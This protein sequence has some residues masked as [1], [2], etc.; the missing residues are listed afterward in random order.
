M[1]EYGYNPGYEDQ[2]VDCGDTCND[3]GG[4][5]H[6]CRCHYNPAPR[7]KRVEQEMNEMRQVDKQERQN[8]LK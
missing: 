3:C 2:F 5:H 6:T 8:M 1:S 7:R 4:C